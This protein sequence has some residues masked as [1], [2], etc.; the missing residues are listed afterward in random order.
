MYVINIQVQCTFTDMQSN[1]EP[2]MHD[3]DD[4]VKQRTRLALGLSQAALKI[5]E[6]NVTL[7]GQLRLTP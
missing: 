3:L 2:P 4:C 5:F 1:C 6:F 7:D